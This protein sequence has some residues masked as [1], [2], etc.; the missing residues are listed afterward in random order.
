MHR[1]M[2][3]GISNIGRPSTTGRIDSPT[4]GRCT[5]T[6]ATMALRSLAKMQRPRRTAVISG[7][8]SSFNS[9]S[10]AASRAASAPHSPMTMP[11]WEAFNAGASLTPSPVIA[12]RS[13][14]CR[15]ARG[16]LSPGAA[17]AQAGP[18]GRPECQPRFARSGSLGAVNPAPV[19]EGPFAFRPA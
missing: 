12:T 1:R 11:V 17:F 13:P 9:T 8:K 2:C 19:I 10:A 6:T 16:G 14:R 5:A 18:C 3:T 4:M 7:E 15:H